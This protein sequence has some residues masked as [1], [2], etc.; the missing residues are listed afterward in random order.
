MN[1]AEVE[2]FQLV[3]GLESS[4]RDAEDRLQRVK[5][6]HAVCQALGKLN[7]WAL[8]PHEREA[9]DLAWKTH[10]ETRKPF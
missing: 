10:V 9:L 4:L 5:T 2:L 1:D 7:Q 8:L 3:Q 6:V